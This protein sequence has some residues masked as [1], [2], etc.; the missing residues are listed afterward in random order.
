MEQDAGP[1]S[2]K[3]E[4]VRPKKEKEED[5]DEAVGR[6]GHN[7]EDEDA[8]EDGGEEAPGPCVENVKLELYGELRDGE[9]SG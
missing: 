4:A 1:G 5:E 2:G 8:D 6:L 3:L 9:Q 7:D